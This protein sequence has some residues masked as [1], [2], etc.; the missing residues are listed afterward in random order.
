M[1]WDSSHGYSA[2]VWMATGSLGQTSKAGELSFLQENLEWTKFCLEMIMGQ[3]M[4][5]ECTGCRRTGLGN[6]H[7]CLPASA[8]L[9][10]IYAQLLQILSVGRPIFQLAPSGT[11]EL[12]NWKQIYHD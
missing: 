3:F 11:A 5:Q 4:G 6:L 7:K 9:S 1:S 2:A 10:Q 8:T 12:E